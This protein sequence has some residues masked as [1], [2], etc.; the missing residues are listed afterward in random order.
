MS[1]FQTIGLLGTSPEA[2]PIYSQTITREHYVRTGLYDCPE[3]VTVLLDFGHLN[4]LAPEPLADYLVDG[5]ER[6]QRAGAEFALICANATHIALPGIADR[7][8]LPVL[9]I[10]DPLAQEARRLGFRRL[11]LMG[12]KTTMSNGFYQREMEARGFECISPSEEDQALVHRVI[13]DE[14]CAGQVLQPT[15]IEL[16]AVATRLHTAGAEA[17]ILGCTELPMALN[18]NN[19]SMPLLDTTRLHAVAALDRA[20]SRTVRS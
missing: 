15:T 18:G 14:L 11:G 16:V 6:L 5:L 1:S 2:P 19:C 3:V 10:F 20:S 7:L 12:T 9:P 8:A 17:V 4:S 13:F